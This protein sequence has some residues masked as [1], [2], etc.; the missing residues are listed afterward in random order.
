MPDTI[1]I[2]GE[3]GTGKTTIAKILCE[4]FAGANI[5]YIDTERNIISEPEGVDYTYI[6]DFGEIYK[7]IQTLKD[8]YK[9]VILDSI[10]LPVLGE[11]AT[12]DLREK[13][14]SLLK[15]QSICYLLKKYS[16]KNKALVV[17]TN[18]PE[19][20]FNK[21]REH[22]L[23][24]FGDKSIYFFKEVWKTDKLSSSPQATACVCRA[25]RS[26]MYG[27]GTELFRVKIDSEGAKIV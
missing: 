4:K 3:S 19:S 25:F 15:A 17:V 6:P 8:G 24:P 2:F 22:V 27:L 23:R 16:Y 5:K 13:G 12:M 1:E 9:L 18:Q 11:F 20:E 26:R 10:G 7:A 21:S 14:N